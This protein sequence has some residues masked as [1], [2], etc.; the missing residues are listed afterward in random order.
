MNSL[1]PILCSEMVA[2]SGAG[3]NIIARQHTGYSNVV[4]FG[5]SA[6][7][8]MVLDRRRRRRHPGAVVGEITRGQ[9]C[10]VT[11]TFKPRRLVLQPLLDEP[12]GAFLS[13]VWR[14]R[15]PFF[16][17]QQ[18]CDLSTSLVHEH[19]TQLG[20]ALDIHDIR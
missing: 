14:Q 10:N 15:C 2:L 12:L 3:R 11:A 4:P 19:Q 18:K 16:Y 20:H 8:T 7:N 1:L 5:Q 17:E 9:T 13:D 6:E